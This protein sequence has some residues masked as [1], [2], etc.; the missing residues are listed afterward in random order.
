MA[1]RHADCGQ[2]RG[3]REPWYPGVTAPPTR[4]LSG[5]GCNRSSDG[6]VSVKLDVVTVKRICLVE[7][8]NKDMSA[9][10]Q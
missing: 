7:P 1:E 4:L 5:I 8:T 2:G 9:T 3:V 6:Y 10:S